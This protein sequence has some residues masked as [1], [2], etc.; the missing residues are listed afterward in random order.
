MKHYFVKE[1]Y[2]NRN[3]RAGTLEQEEKEIFKNVMLR[4]VHLV[5]VPADLSV[6]QS[7]IRIDS[8]SH[9]HGFSL[10]SLSDSIQI[11]AQN[12]YGTFCCKTTEIV[13]FTDIGDIYNVSTGRDAHEFIIRRNRNGGTLYFSSPERDQII[14]VGATIF[15]MKI[16]YL[17]LL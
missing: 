6:A 16:M 2:C 9:L 1:R 8:V 11:K 5:K 12:I 15:R 4:Q 17:L 14:K 3:I 13:P 10:S 7:H